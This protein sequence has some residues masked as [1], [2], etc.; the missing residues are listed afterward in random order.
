MFA[1]ARHRGVASSSSSRTGE[2]VTASSGRRRKRCFGDEVGELR[3]RLELDLLPEEARAKTEL[4]DHLGGVALGEVDP[5]QQAMRVAQRLHD[6]G[7]KRRLERSPIRTAT[8]SR[9]PSASNAWRQGCRSRSRSI[10][11]SRRRVREELA[12]EPRRAETG[13]DPARTLRRREQA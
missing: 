3:R 12:R 10:R 1:R 8:S 4:T 5:E 2:A 13:L 11:T 7:R 9:S 6:D